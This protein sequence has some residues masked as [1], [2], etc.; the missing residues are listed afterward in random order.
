VAERDPA[1]CEILVKIIRFLEV[2]P[3]LR[4]L[5]DQE[6]VR[7]HCIPRDSRVRVG[8]DQFMR[9]IIELTLFVQ[10][11]EDTAVQRHHLDVKWIVINDLLEYL[12]RLLKVLVIEILFSLYEPDVQR[13]L[14]IQQ[15]QDGH[16]SCAH[17][18]CSSALPFVLLDH[19]GINVHIIS[20]HEMWSTERLS[21]VI[22]F[23]EIVFYSSGAHAIAVTR[24]LHLESQ[25]LLF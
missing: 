1:C 13:F 12:I 3:C 21:L 2:L 4:I 15:V 9:N 22:I 7:A 20:V 6:V 23:K 5:L 19:R 16:Y 10:L 24:I 11:N 8:T 14:L 25:A 17:W 18:W